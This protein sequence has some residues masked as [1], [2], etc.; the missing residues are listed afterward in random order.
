MSETS[1]SVVV[2]ANS[3]HRRDLSID[4]GIADSNNA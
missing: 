2:V 1:D 3:A 4:Q